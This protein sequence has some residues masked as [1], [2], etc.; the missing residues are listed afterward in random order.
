MARCTRNDLT[1]R[2]VAKNGQRDAEVEDRARSSAGDEA[3]ER[4]LAALPVRERRLQL[5]GVRHREHRR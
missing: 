1:T 2:E 5:A 3:H 4:L